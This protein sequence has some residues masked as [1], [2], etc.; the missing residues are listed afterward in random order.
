M[1]VVEVREAVVVLGATEDAELDVVPWGRVP[2][3][4]IVPFQSVQ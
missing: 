1:L 4:G 2:L 3:A